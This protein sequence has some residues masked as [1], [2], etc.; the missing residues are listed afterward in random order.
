MIMSTINE[1]LT[2][3]VVVEDLAD[4]ELSEQVIIPF[5]V[6]KEDQKFKAVP[7]LSDAERK[8]AAYRR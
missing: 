4:K 6:F 3:S 5:K 8:R 1:E 2:I 7:L